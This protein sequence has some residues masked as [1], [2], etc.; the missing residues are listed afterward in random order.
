MHYTVP[1]SSTQAKSPEE[2]GGL[3][4]NTA[5]SDKLS[6]RVEVESSVTE[7]A[8][9]AQVLL[10]HPGARERARLVSLN[11]LQLLLLKDSSRLV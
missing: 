3:L 6:K 9:Q 4:T 2:G 1:I 10:S 11:V 7:A 8:F 5:D